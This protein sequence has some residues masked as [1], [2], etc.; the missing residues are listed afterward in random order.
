MSSAI[1]RNGKHYWHVMH[2]FAECHN[3]RE[4]IDTDA[5]RHFLDTIIS[6]LPCQRCME[7]A[8]EYMRENWPRRPMTGRQ[9]RTFLYVFHNVV[10]AEIGKRQ[11]SPEQYEREV[12]KRGPCYGP[13]RMK[14]RTPLAPPGHSAR[15]FYQI[16][17]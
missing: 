8:R 17:Q 3:Q 16:L 6:L 15:T 13:H 2:R 9:L 12:E 5:V 10:N 11:M 4:T 7:H 14:Y 1:E